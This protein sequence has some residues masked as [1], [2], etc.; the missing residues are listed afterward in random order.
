[1]SVSRWPMVKEGAA[2]WVETTRTPTDDCGMA[3]NGEGVAVGPSN[4]ASRSGGKKPT[5]LAGGACTPPPQYLEVGDSNCQC[6]SDVARNF[7]Q[8]SVLLIEQGWKHL[9][10]FT[11][12]IF[13]R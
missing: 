13:R 4:N 3:V 8:V 2:A 7:F 10:T 1:M 9:Q 12:R 6:L 11:A 5:E